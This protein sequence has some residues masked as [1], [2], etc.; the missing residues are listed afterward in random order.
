MKKIWIAICTI[1]SL[2]SASLIGWYIW[3]LAAA[4]TK[5]VSQTYEVGEQVVFNSDGST[6][7]KSFIDV[8]V[9]DNVFEIKFN[10]MLDENQDAFYSQGLQYI[11]NSETEE[12]NFNGEYESIA[13]EK[14]GDKVLDKNT[15]KYPSYYYNTTH[16]RVLN[17]KIYD[18]ITTYNYMS[19]DDYETTLISSNLIDEETMFKIQIGDDLYGMKFKNIDLSKSFYLGKDKYFIK[20]TPYGLWVNYYYDIYEN[21]RACDIQYFAELIFNACSSVPAGTSQTV[22]FEFGDLFDYYEYDEENKQYSENTVETDKLSKILADVKSY[23]C[24]KVNVHDGELTSS[25]QS[26]FNCF[27]GNSNY[28]ILNSFDNYFYGRTLVEVDV[29]KFDFIET[30]TPGEYYLSL[31]EEFKAFYNDFNHLVQFDIIIDLDYL[32]SLNITFLGVKQ[33]SLNGLKIFNAET[34]QTIDGEVIK[35]EIN[36]A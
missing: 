33:E 18:N 8:N 5:I 27:A 13:Y 9:Y 4:P 3:I 30:S 31:N 25:T 22:V 21:Y 7:K 36:Y 1:I 26:I 29:N 16:T 28:N 11:L 12:F 32:S 17:N 23:Y 24:I 10:Y 14:N 35:G 2:I 19:G 6:T 20:S 15:S 34:T